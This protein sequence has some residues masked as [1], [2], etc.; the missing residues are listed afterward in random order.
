MN[1]L[2]NYSTS[3]LRRKREDVETSKMV[4]A[5]I[6]KLRDEVQ[7]LSIDKT[8]LLKEV[9]SL[10]QD[11]NDDVLGLMKVVQDLD[12]DKLL[13]AESRICRLQLVVVGQQSIA[14]EQDKKIDLLEK[15][16]RMNWSI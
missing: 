1:V 6:S 8:R 10:K 14:K 11:S 12:G 3:S 16:L 9:E 2:F 15:N 5:E 4:D 7:R 13:R